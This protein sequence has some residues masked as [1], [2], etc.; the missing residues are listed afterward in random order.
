MSVCS[1]VSAQSNEDHR[2]PVAEREH[3][4][5]VLASKHCS[6]LLSMMNLFT[7]IEVKSKETE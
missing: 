7:S 3:R 2:P 4:S 5:V 6:T 1:M